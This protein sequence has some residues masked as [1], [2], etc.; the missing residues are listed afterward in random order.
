[1]KI[2]DRHGTVVFEVLPPLNPEDHTSRD[3]QNP[4][5]EVAAGSRSRPMIA[6]ATARFVTP[7]HGNTI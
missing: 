3:E 5:Y 4:P 6:P 2:K 1:M 7:E